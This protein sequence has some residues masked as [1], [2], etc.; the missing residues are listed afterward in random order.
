MICLFFIRI[1]YFSWELFV[2]HWTSILRT[3]E[4]LTILNISISQSVIFCLARRNLSSLLVLWASIRCLHQWLWAGCHLCF[5]ESYPLSFNFLLLAHFVSFSW[6]SF[7]NIQNMKLFLQRTQHFIFL[8][9]DSILVH[10][11]DHFISALPGVIWTRN[12]R[13]LPL[14]PLLGFSSA[15]LLKSATSSGFFADSKRSSQ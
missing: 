8:P 3:V 2:F 15:T 4:F 14:L 13:F 10:P 9:H 7:Q 1:V 12:S 11:N 6:W 5:R